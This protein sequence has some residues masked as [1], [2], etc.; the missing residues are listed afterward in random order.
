LASSPKRAAK[1]GRQKRAPISRSSEGA[2]E[3]TPGQLFLKLIAKK[4][5]HSDS[6][7]A[8]AV[9]KLFPG[10]SGGGK[11]IS[12]W[13]EKDNPRSPAAFM[14]GE[15][16]RK[17]G[18]SWFSGLAGLNYFGHSA[19]FAAVLGSCNPAVLRYMHLL[20]PLLQ[21]YDDLRHISV[22]DVLP[23]DHTILNGKAD[24]FLL[25]H[26]S[27]TL[28][29]GTPISQNFDDEAEL[30]NARYIARR[31]WS[32][33]DDFIKC[34]NSG[35]ETW[36]EKCNGT[37]RDIEYGRNLP[38]PLNAAY[39]VGRATLTPQLSREARDFAVRSI[40]LLWLCAQI[41][42]HKGADLEFL[43]QAVS[44]PV[45]PQARTARA[46]LFCHAR[47]AEAVFNWKFVLS[48]DDLAKII[49]RVLEQ[50]YC[51]DLGIDP[52]LLLKSV[53]EVRGSHADTI[54]ISKYW[55]AVTENLPAENFEVLAANPSEDDPPR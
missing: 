52:A 14:L 32:F 13:R 4:H 8:N 12:R 2:A 54:D 31:I 41:G 39:E 34:V 37:A 27:D 49:W 22:F 21:M 38:P 48:N 42:L 45:S 6:D 15:A 1:S 50:K 36:N 20:F 33:E 17:L 5:S 35:F 29:Y 40:I 43:L 26:V 44:S 51:K 7:I 28:A 30:L 10:W 19:D 55:S 9:T 3:Q 46:L 53:N 24:D 18:Y 25:R 16:L 23:D 11:A 47:L